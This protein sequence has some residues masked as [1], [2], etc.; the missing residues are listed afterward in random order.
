MHLAAVAALLSFEAAVA[1]ADQSSTSVPASESSPIQSEAPPA[2]ASGAVV[3]IPGG[4]APIQGP[5]DA[6]A[7]PPAYEPAL[8]QG[9]PPEL[10]EADPAQPVATLSEALRRAY[11]TNPELL[12]ERARL[13]SIDFRLPQ[14]RA[15]YG[16]QLRYSASYGYQHNRYEQPI[17]GT[18][19]R[20]GW[21]STASAV[22]AQPLFA[23]GRLRANEDAARAQIA[24]QRAALQSAEQQTLLETIAAYAGVLRGR[25]GLSIALENAELLT[26]QFS[27]TRTRLELGESTATDFRQ[28]ETRLELAR[29]QLLTA[30]GQEVSSD[31]LFLQSVGAPAGA[32]APP[33]PLQL[34][35]QTLEDAYAYAQSRNPVLASAYARERISRAELEAARADLLPRVELQGQVNHGTSSIAGPE[36]SQ[37]ELRGAITISG[38][39]DAGSRQGRIGEL[40]AVNDADWRLI[41][42]ALRENRAELADAWSQWQAQTAA[43]VQLD[44]ASQAAEQALE[45]A[46]LQERA[47]LR[48]TLEILEL[49]Q[50]LLQVRT[51]LNTAAADAYIAQ[52]R[53]LAAMGVLSHEHLLP[54]APGYDEHEHFEQVDGRADIPLLTPA[55]RALDSLTTPKLADR[56]VR[57]PTAPLAVDRSATEQQSG[58]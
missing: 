4:S 7:G 36:L 26:Q 3:V 35:V 5:F 8:P 45:G 32:L 19:Q 13:R 37:T 17:G 40:A 58:F 44:I 27:D 47:G 49:A 54:D 22:L 39:L 33:D 56:P 48:T 14:A 53:V 29:A 46:L 55:V 51:S 6:P 12:A 15:Q 11:W 57:D 50:D 18:V 16:P 43:I 28:V 25:T 31:A 24:F 10:V 20:Q 9:T 42:A 23:F 38:V 1:Q 21:A 52:A 30:Q 41:D 34:P 2:D